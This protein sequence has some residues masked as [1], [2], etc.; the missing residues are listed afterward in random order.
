MIAYERADHEAS[1]DVSEHGW[2]TQREFATYVSVSGKAYILST[3]IFFL[4]D[5]QIDFVSQIDLA[6][7]FMSNGISF[8]IPSSSVIYF[9]F[10]IKAVRM[11]VMSFATL[12]SSYLTCLQDD[13]KNDI[14]KIKRTSRFISIVACLIES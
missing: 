3:H 4:S 5:V 11:I 13:E 9:L 8:K 7:C 14:K 2:G 6:D 10:A 12:F 1:N